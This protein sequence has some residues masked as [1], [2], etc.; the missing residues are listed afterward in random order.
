MFCTAVLDTKCWLWTHIRSIWAVRPACQPDMELSAQWHTL[1]ELFINVNTEHRLF[2]SITCVHM[3]LFIMTNFIFHSNHTS[4]NQTHCNQDNSIHRVNSVFH[5][6]IFTIAETERSTDKLNQTHTYTRKMLWLVVHSHCTSGTRTVCYCGS[7]LSS[8]THLCL[9]S[10]LL[11]SSTSHSQNPTPSCLSV[12]KHLSQLQSTPVYACVSVC[13][14][15]SQHVKGTWLGISNTHK[16]TVGGMHV[17][18][19]N[20]WGHVKISLTDT[21]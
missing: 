4:A 14:K 18:C 11:L 7:S 17:H 8:P 9:P 19:W 1:C 21:L 20:R 13:S 12:N 3:V 15:H 16:H 6:V 10:P 2:Y 5:L